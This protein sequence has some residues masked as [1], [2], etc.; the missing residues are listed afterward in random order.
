MKDI[1]TYS[2]DFF[3]INDISLAGCCVHL[4]CLEGD[5]S[6]VFNGKCF[7]LCRNSLVVTSTPLK[8]KNIAA[9]ESARFEWFAASNDFLNGLLPANN[10]SIGGSIS[11]NEN[12]VIPL[13]DAN[14]T[15]FLADIR[16]IH[17]RMADDGLRFYREIMGSLCLTMVYD[18]FEF[19][20]Q[21]YGAVQHTD[22][23]GYIVKALVDLLST[24]ICRTEREMSYF[25]RRLNVSPKYLSATVR[26]MTGHSATSYIDRY[27]VPILRELLDD[28]R[29][30][31]TQVAEM[32][33]FS[34]LSYFSRYC[35]KHLGMSPAEY[36][37]S[38]QP[39]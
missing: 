7:H 16:R 5:G 11:L 21:H 13:S 25:A 35:K 20:S 14:A 12:P 3:R 8:I 9:P 27:A 22:R 30:S 18:I 29:L 28:Q 2:T 15:R 17:E 36:R 4:I 23:A 34:T 10:Y 37:K 33:N 38:L 24:G 1:F 6:F 19:H 31:I 26:R 39:E 32:M